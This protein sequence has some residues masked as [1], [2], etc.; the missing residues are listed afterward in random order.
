[1]D[2][3]AGISSLETRGRFILRGL[4]LQPN[5]ATTNYM[6][7]SLEELV[8]YVIAFSVEELRKQGKLKEEEKTASVEPHYSTIPC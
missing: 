6:T 7:K 2:I 1:M 4:G 5:E 8:T 3:S